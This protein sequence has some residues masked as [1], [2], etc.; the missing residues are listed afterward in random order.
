[1]ILRS[2]IH[3]IKKKRDFTY[4]PLYFFLHDMRLIQ[5]EDY[6]HGETFYEKKKQ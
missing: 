5:S 3:V 1:M 6:I 2:I 4:G